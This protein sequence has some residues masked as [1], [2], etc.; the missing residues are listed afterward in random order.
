MS[1]FGDYE[2]R[3]LGYFGRGTQILFNGKYYTVVEAGKPRCASG[4]P[5]TD[6]YVLV[7]NAD[8]TV[9]IKISYK[10]EN[11]DF[12]EN[13]ITSV[14]AEQLFGSEWEKVIENS[15]MEIE[16]KFRE[17]I[18]IYREKHGRTEKGSITLGWKF[19]L[20]NKPGGILSGKM[21]LSRQQVYD[22]YAGTN[23]SDDK[24]NAVVNGNVIYNSGIADYILMV[25]DI[26]SAQEVI[27]KMIPIDDYI[28]LHPDIYF[29]CKALNYRTFSHRYDGNR[30][31][32]VQVDWHI[33]NGKLSADL[34]FNK[35][36]T[37][38]GNEMANR[39]LACMRQ[40][41]IRTTDDINYDN[42]DV[43]SVN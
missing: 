31:L 27:N 43:Y 33:N 4:E 36:L 14:R 28:N 38:N 1:V 39:L 2:R 3:I 18:L 22:V 40:L 16:D 21:K 7:E 13:K 5:K 32:S 11:A 19:E 12:L 20:L 17:R 8:G 10:K 23:L 25:D 37:M 41:E 29:A 34:I 9:E 30:P 24:K 6:I 42:T 26:S 35:P 15:T